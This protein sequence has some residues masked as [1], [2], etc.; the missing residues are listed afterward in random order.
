MVRVRFISVAVASREV[1]LEVLLLDGVDNGGIRKFDSTGGR[2]LS[3]CFCQNQPALKGGIH[4]GRCG[5]HSCRRVRYG[6]F[7]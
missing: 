1:F 2:V 7:G 5:P 3:G 4:F 6:M